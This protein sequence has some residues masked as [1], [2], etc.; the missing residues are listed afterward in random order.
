MP[1]IL[2]EEPI[3]PTTTGATVGVVAAPSAAVKSFDESSFAFAF[4]CIVNS[5][6]LVGAV[7]MVLL[8][9]GE[10][11]GMLDTW[12][13]LLPPDGTMVWLELLEVILLALGPVTAEPLFSSEVAN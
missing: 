12:V 2:Q 7:V 8:V 10:A 5:P 13:V 9:I 3:P 6:S 1:Q 4:R 11:V